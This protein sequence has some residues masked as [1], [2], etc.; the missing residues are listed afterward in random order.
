VKLINIIR[1]KLFKPHATASIQMIHTHELGDDEARVQLRDRLYETIQAGAEH[2]EQQ[3]WSHAPA[4]GG[5]SKPAGDS[6]VLMVSASVL[7]LLRVYDPK[8]SRY[9]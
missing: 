1:E 4:G 6:L 9:S 7:N 5:P 3:P 2:V 8:T